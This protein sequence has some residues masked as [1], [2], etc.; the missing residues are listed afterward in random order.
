MVAKAAPRELS[1]IAFF[2]VM[3]GAGPAVTLYLSKLVIDEL[4]LL[5]QQGPVA[6][7]RG[8]ITTDSTL[9]W[10][11]AGTVGLRLLVEIT[12]TVDIL[13]FASLRDRVQG[14]V[15]GQVLEKIATFNDIA[16]FESPDLLNIVQLTQKGVGRVQRLSFMLSGT[17]KGLLTFLPSVLLAASLDWWIPLLLIG[18]TAPSIWVE[19][20]HR[21]RSWR[22]ETTQAETSRNMDIY[23]RLIRG[24]NYAKEIRLFSLQR[25]MVSRW[26]DF[27]FQRFR[28][29]AQVRKEGAIAMAFWSCI[30]NLGAALPYVFVVV[31][32]VEGRFTLGDIALYTGIIAQMQGGLQR[33]IANFGEL[34]D[35]TLA[36]KPIFQLLDLQPELTSPPQ[37][38][39]VDIWQQPAKQTGIEV[40]DLVFA[41]PGSDAP[42]LKGV[43][44]QIRPNEMVALVG[45]NGAGKTTLGKLLCRLYD[46]TQ[47]S[48]YW[49]GKDYRELELRELRDRI[50]VV[51]QDYARFPTT[52]RENVGWGYQPS[53]DEDNA[54]QEVLEE[55]GVA[56]LVKNYELG[57]ETPLGKEL[58]DG[59]DLSGGQ[60][61][62][63][64]IARSLLRMGTADLM[65]FDEPTAALDPKNEQEIYDIFRNVARGRMAVVVSHR[66]ALAKMA[67][68]IVVLEHGQVIE[69]G[70]HDELMALDGVYADMFMRQA[71]SYV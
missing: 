17:L 20:R 24:E 8:V 3:T 62:R 55:A 58:E 1:Q 53:L 26:K 7:W 34:Y 22:V 60:W 50:A 71:S 57:L 40:Q 12:S 68:R 38:Q 67:D 25:I 21:R 35:V 51:M 43:N 65:V 31:G 44:F 30:S 52:L 13:L 59:V 66:L 48:I 64:A 23:G 6:D 18:I 61:Q 33:L 47:G 10:A 56:R 69:E 16:L 70:S 14:A 39:A 37:E 45:E 19:M 49:N 9:L 2:N 41:Y 29:M 42:I 63:V 36:T 46:P 5:V 15:Q 32:V 28:A 27:Y 11:L 54:I 4:S